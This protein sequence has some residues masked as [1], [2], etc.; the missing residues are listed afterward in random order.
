MKPMNSTPALM[1]GDNKMSLESLIPFMSGAYPV[2]SLRNRLGPKAFG[3]LCAQ[4]GVKR[5][6]SAASRLKPLTTPRS[7]TDA[8]A[9]SDDG[10]SEEDDDADE[11]DESNT[12]WLEGN[13]GEPSN[14]QKTS[15]FEEASPGLKDL[16]NIPPLP[17]GRNFP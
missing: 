8:E 9:S 11:G 5:L 1:T 4:G 13:G 2:S 14:T 3:S 12:S 16:V 10:G 6:F 17:P 7:S 15:T